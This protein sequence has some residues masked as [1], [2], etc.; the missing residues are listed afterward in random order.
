MRRMMVS[1]PLR[2][3]LLPTVQRRE[4]LV[5][6]V[7]ADRPAAAHAHQVLVP[8]ARAQVLPVSPVAHAHAIAG[9][10]LGAL[11]R[12]EQ[13][14]RRPGTAPPSFHCSGRRLQTPSPAE[15]LAIGMLAKLACPRTDGD[16]GTDMM[17]LWRWRSGLASVVV[18][19]TIPFLQWVQY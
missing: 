7:A 3:K 19:V 6:L 9:R 11:V 12:L 4:L 13:V 1:V 2:V 15:M 18:V 16:P 5:S 10:E 8:L 17:T 14:R